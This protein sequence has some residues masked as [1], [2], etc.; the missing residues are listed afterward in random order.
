M[1]YE[2]YLRGVDLYSRSQLPLAVEC[3]EKSQSWIQ[4][5]R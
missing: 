3:F 5:P 2:Y 1:A 4:N